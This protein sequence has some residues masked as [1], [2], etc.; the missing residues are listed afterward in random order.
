MKPS[1]GGQTFDTA[2][3]GDGVLANKVIVNELYASA[4]DDGF[5]KIR[6]DEVGV[7]D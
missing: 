4:T 3:T 7:D 5:T 6:H 1:N 2:M